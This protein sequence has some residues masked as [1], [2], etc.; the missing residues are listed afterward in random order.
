MSKSST[1]TERSAGLTVP[2]RWAG[3]VV[4][5]RSGSGTFPASQPH[6]TFWYY[7]LAPKVHIIC[8]LSISWKFLSTRAYARV[9]SLCNSAWHNRV[10]DPKYLNL[11]L[12]DPYLVS[13]YNFSITSFEFCQPGQPDFTLNSRVWPPVTQWPYSIFV[14]SSVNLRKLKG[15]QCVI[16][17]WK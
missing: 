5:P 13:L 10:P 3:W 8:F 4:C 17:L 2:D 15:I 7:V 12:F 6:R 1:S 9:L 11:S 16:S 14:L